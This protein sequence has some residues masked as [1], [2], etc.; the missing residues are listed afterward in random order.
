[1]KKSLYVKI[2]THMFIIGIA[3]AA[4]FSILIAA[5]LFVTRKATVS[6]GNSLGDSAAADARHLLIEQAR[7]ELSRMVQSKAAITDEKMS[8]TA[9]DVRIISQI[10]T[11]IKSNPSQYGRRAISFP[12]TSNTEG[13]IT[14]M[15]QIPENTT[16]GMFQGEIGLMANIQDTLLAIQ[17]NNKNAGT[18][19]IATEYGITIGADADSALGTPYFEPRTRPWYTAAKQADG[20]IWTD[21]FEDYLGRGLAITCAKPFY[22]AYGRIAGVAGMGMYLNDLKEVVSGTEFGINGHAYLVN[23]KGEMIISDTISKDENGNMIHENILNSDTFPRETAQKMVNREN[24]IE[25]V[26]ID[27]KE[28]LIAYHRLDTL[29][30]SLAIILN[31][32]EISSLA[33]TL[34]ENIIDLKKSTIAIIDKDIIWIAVITGFILIFIIAGVLSLTG[35]LATDITEPIEKLTI[36][37]ARIGAG[38]LEH[39]LDIKTGDEL[40]LLATSFN[41]MITGIKTITAENERLK[42][43]S[44]EK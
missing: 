18:T 32:D 16:L 27:G 15:V 31:A 33:L 11:I 21:V 41:S 12:D 7:N 38:D 9:D 8:A 25:H 17:T 37:A 35:Q 29:P 34:E 44:S 30:W 13:R 10:A 3:T 24:G 2:R 39:V 5:G 26:T 42:I 23:E 36:D 43:A 28:K 1:L 14:A 20:L 40:E 19:Y 22:D 4:V 6:A